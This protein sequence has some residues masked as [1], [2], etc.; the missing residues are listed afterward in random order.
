MKDHPPESPPRHL[1]ALMCNRKFDPIRKSTPE[2]SIPGWA[3]CLGSAA[4]R[5]PVKIVKHDSL[6]DEMKLLECNPFL[7]RARRCTIWHLVVESQPVQTVQSEAS[8]KSTITPDNQISPNTLCGVSDEIEFIVIS[9]YPVPYPDIPINEYDICP[10]TRPQQRLN[11][12][13]QQ[14]KEFW[15]ISH[16]NPSWFKAAAGRILRPIFVR[17]RVFLAV[18]SSSFLWSYFSCHSSVMYQM[19]PEPWAFAFQ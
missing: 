3:C 14:S 7:W 6:T 2:P 12:Y 18:F 13:T 17:V 1:F 10:L 9:S 15:T 16:K 19:K 11:P 8:K 5:F 4:M